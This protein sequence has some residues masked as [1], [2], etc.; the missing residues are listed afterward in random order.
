MATPDPP[1][2]SKKKIVGVAAFFVLFGVGFL[3]AAYYLHRS[4]GFW[5]RKLLTVGIGTIVIFGIALVQGLIFL[6][7]ADRSKTKK[8]A[9][10]A[11]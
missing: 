11:T 5:R 2:F 8:K 10:D 4:E 7:S 9:D 6:F 1:P 3:V